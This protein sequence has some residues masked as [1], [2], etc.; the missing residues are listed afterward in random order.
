MRQLLKGARS[1]CTVRSSA[2]ILARHKD[3]GLLEYLLRLLPGDLRSGGF[4]MDIAGALGK[5]PSSVKL[6]QYR[7]FAELRRLL[8]SEVSA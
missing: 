6:I 7:A 3:P 2:R 4:D 5:S 8:A 1:T